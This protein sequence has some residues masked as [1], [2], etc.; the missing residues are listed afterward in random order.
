MQP[1]VKRLEFLAARNGAKLLAIVLY[2]SDDPSR[3]RRIRKLRNRKTILSRHEVG[4]NTR[5]S[6]MSCNLKMFWIKRVMILQKY[7]MCRG[8]N[9]ADIFNHDESSVS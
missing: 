7:V 4:G 2:R 1:F 3:Y 6:E 5:I 9:E 8:I